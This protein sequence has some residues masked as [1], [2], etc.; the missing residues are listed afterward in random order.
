MERDSLRLA[1]NY[2]RNDTPKRKAGIRWSA[3][4]EI[5]N[6][7]HE[8]LEK[9]KFF[10]GSGSIILEKRRNPKHHDRYKYIISQLRPL[11]PQLELIVKEK[12]RRFLIEALNIL[13]KRTRTHDFIGEDRLAWIH[14]EIKK[15][16]SPLDYLQHFS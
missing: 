13:H 5:S 9:A 4:I 3:R 2:V 14:D 10:V 12:Q 11:L 1:R 8:L 15:L 6:I 7:N 16:N